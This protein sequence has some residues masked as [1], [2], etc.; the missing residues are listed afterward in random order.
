MFHG[1]SLT[2]IADIMAAHRCS[3]DVNVHPVRRL[4]VGV[5]RTSSRPGR[6]F[7]VSRHCIITPQPPLL[8]DL[9]SRSIVKRRQFLKPRVGGERKKR[10]I[11]GERSKQDFDVLCSKCDGRRAQPASLGPG[12][13]EVK[14]DA[15]RCPRCLWLF[16]ST[17]NTAYESN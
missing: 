16:K 5:L 8:Q 1:E 12:H 9:V 13:A 7:P 15:P 2:V 4:L 11:P 3:L 14:G 6:L 17:N 10:T